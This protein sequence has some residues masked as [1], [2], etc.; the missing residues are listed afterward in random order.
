MDPSKCLEILQARSTRVDP[1]KEFFCGPASSTTAESLNADEIDTL[2]GLDDI[3]L[4]N[5]FTTVQGERVQV[6]L[7][8]RVQG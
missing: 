6:Q 8:E 7:R 3:G 2:T 5:L 4:M 1:E